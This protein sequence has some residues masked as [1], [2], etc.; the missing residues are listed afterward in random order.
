MSKEQVN[1]PEH[2]GGK[3]NPYETIKI[4]DAMGWGKEFCLGNVIKYV[5]RA[6]KKDNNSSKQDLNKAKWY[7][8]H[9][10]ELIEKEKTNKDK[11]NDK[12]DALS[13]SIDYAQKC[14]KYRDDF[15]KFIRERE[16]EKDP[17]F[18][19]KENEAIKI[20]KDIHNITPEFKNRVVEILK[21]EPCST[22]FSSELGVKRTDIFNK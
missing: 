12:L 13:Y 16:T 2:Y 20:L 7:L 10:I 15:I 3:D 18:N 4:I 1:H 22:P 21:L 14:K 5:T 11:H 19:L 6:G 17:V 8:E 9:A